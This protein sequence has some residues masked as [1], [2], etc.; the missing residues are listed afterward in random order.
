MSDNILKLIPI[1]PA[2][3]P[4]E[5]LIQQA[6]AAVKLL[7]PSANEVSIKQTEIP[8]FRD[9]GGNWERIVCPI[10]AA[11][12]DEMW[13]REAM[14]KAHEKH[15][16]DLNVTVPCCGS[17]TSLNELKYE[18]PAGF[19]RFSIEILNPNRDLTDEELQ[20][21]ETILDSKLRKI[22]AHY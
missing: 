7:F 15:L 13:W 16:M 3:M 9:Q 21:I 5:G 18:S 4:Q 20:S 17:R 14:N 19:S 10:C 12:I 1:S 8:Q 11:V 2:Y 6:L 22:W